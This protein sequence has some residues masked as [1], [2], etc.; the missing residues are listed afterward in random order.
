MAAIGNG[1]P[2][3]DWRG[4]LRDTMRGGKIL[5]NW[6]KARLHAQEAPE[7]MIELEDSG[8]LDRDEDGPISQGDFSGRRSH[9]SATSATARAGDDPRP[10]AA[11]RTDLGIDVFMECTVARGAVPR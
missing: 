8:A 11:R 9:G 4:Q 1:W 3:D 10:P 6:R 5:D 7:Q 2:E